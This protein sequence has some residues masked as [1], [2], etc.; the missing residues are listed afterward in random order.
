MRDRARAAARQE[1]LMRIAASIVAVISVAATSYFVIGHQSPAPPQSVYRTVA[2]E[3]STVRLADGSVVMLS[4]KSEMR[5]SFSGRRRDVTLVNGEAIFTVAKDHHRPFVVT[6]GRREVTAVGTVFDVKLD[7]QRLGVVLLEGRIEVGSPGLLIKKQRQV[8][9]AG[10]RITVS[11]NSP[12]VKV[13]KADLARDTAWLDDRVVFEGETLDQAVA[14]INRYTDQTLTIA[15]PTL[16]NLSVS[17]MFRTNQ[18][19]RFVDAITGYY[20]IEAQ[21]TPSGQIR[22]LRK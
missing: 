7:A 4:S 8:L 11:L 15:D 1:R 13:E 14:E 22:L 2:G 3:R 16:K 9:L 20:P 10:Q 18:P 6:A 17:G 19:E 5:V 21:R 12:N